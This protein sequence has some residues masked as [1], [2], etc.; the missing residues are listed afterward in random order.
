M[1][2]DDRDQSLSQGRGGDGEGEEEE[3]EP[4]T[5][6]ATQIKTLVHDARMCKEA[7]ME[8]RVVVAKEGKRVVGSNGKK[9]EGSTRTKGGD[10]GIRGNR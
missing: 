8:A 9:R 2:S 3:E 6:L 7:S 10:G 1:T 5:K 4:C